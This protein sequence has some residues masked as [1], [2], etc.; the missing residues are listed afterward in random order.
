MFRAV[1][2]LLLLAFQVDTFRPDNDLFLINHGRPILDAHNCYPYDGKWEDRIDRALSTGFPVAIEQDIAPYRDPR[3]GEVIAKVTHRSTAT[4]QE[5]TL[6]QYF[7]ER[8]RPIVEKAFEENKKETWPL[9]ILHFDFKDNAPPTLEAVWKVL[10][11]HQDWFTTAPKTANDSDLTRLDWKPL[12]VLTEDN[13]TQEQV[14][15][16]RLA[17]GDKLRVFGSAHLNQT[18]LAGLNE[19]QREYALAHAAPTLLLTTRATN[20]R[21]WWNNSWLEVE[22]GGQRRAGAWTA[23]ADQRLRALVDHAHRMGYWI[24]FYTLDGFGPSQSEGW[25]AAYNFGST[26]AVEQRW[27]A[28]LSDGV[29]LI[30]TDQ[31]E[32]LRTFMRQAG[33]VGSR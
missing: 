22:E 7:F 26:A 27:R 33:R 9:I 14:F 6:K 30:A 8:V 21:R 11:E 12:L 15:Y 29:D 5:P 28:A 16:R 2:G 19:K 3:S 23:A 10:G 32:E 18:L 4:A 1:L 24:R 25:D 17:V 31:Y 13:D 20:Y